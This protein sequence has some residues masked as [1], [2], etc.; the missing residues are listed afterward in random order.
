LRKEW[1]IKS[2]KAKKHILCEKPFGV[3][4]KEC[5]EMMQVCRENNVLLMDGVMFMHHDR[6]LSMEGKLKEELG[7]S[8]KDQSV[9]DCFNQTLRITSAFSFSGNEEFFQNNVRTD[10]SKEPLG[11]LG[12]LGW[13]NIRFSMW[14]CQ[15]KKPKRVK[16]EI[17]QKTEDNVPLDCSC[18]LD[19]GDHKTASFDCSFCLSLRTWAEISNAKGVLKLDD[20]VIPQSTD[21][22]KFETS[23]ASTTARDVT[24]VNSEKS[25]QTL[26]CNQHVRMIENFSRLCKRE[27]L[28]MKD[29]SNSFRTNRDYNDWEF[30]SQ[31][32]LDTQKVIDGLMK[33]GLEESGGWVDV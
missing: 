19:F 16:C 14:V 24:F 6:L 8:I 25:H 20:F 29:G 2:A 3:N 13:Y 33:S 12:D 26:M 21:L 15:W 10:N 27:S 23:V 9:S 32:A 4:A 11:C 22:V 18:W 1:V 28:V 30:W 31:V 7:Y 5:E 17:Y